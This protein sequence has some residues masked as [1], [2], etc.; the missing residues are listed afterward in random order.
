M[1]GNQIGQQTPFPEQLGRQILP[2]FGADLAALDRAQDLIGLIGIQLRKATRSAQPGFGFD[3]IEPPM[4]AFGGAWQTFRPVSVALVFGDLVHDH[5]QSGG[6]RSFRW[7]GAHAGRDRAQRC[8]LGITEH[9]IGDSKRKPSINDVA[10]LV[11]PARRIALGEY[12]IGR[13]GI[14]HG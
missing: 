4:P 14:I 3:R 9:I 8:Q 5:R 13:E 12:V 1:R 11:V 2:W 6:C 7:V 10:S